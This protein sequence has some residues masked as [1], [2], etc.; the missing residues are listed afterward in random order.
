MGYIE[1]DKTELTNLK[2]SLSKEF[3]R[4]NRA[5]SYA[6]STIINCNTRKYHGLLI[7][8]MDQLDGEN[9]VLL[10]ALDETIIQHN[11]EF[12]LAVR[13]YPGVMHPGHKYLKEFHADP[14]P[15]LTY[16]VGGV[17]LQK[18]M[19]LSSNEDQVLI[20]YTLLDAHS[21]TTLKLHPFLAFRNIHKLCKAN[22]DVNTKFTKIENGIR[23]RMYNVYPYLY[24]QISKKN[25]YVPAPCWFYN[26]EYSEEES[27]GYEFTEDLYV[28]GYFEFPI[29]KGESIIF[30]ASLKEDQPKQLKQKFLEEIE[31]RIPRDNFENCL[32]NS[33]QQFIVHKKNKIEIVAGYPWFGP[34]MR[35]TFIALPGLTLSMGDFQTA[36]DVLLQIT[37]Q[38]KDGLFKNGDNEEIISVDT[39]LWYFW[40]IQQYVLYTG[41]DEESWKDFGSKMKSIL[42]KYKSGFD[43]VKMHDN[44]L[45]CAAE[46]GK[47]LTWMDAVVNGVPVTP[48]YGYNVEVNALWY[49]ALMFTLELAEK[50]NDQKFIKEWKEWPEKIKESFISTFWSEKKRFLSDY[51]TNGEQNWHVRP[52]QVFAISLPYSMLSKE[53][54]KSVLDIVEGELLTSRGL[55]TLSPNSSKY[56]GVYEG[57]PESRDNAY[58]QGTVWPWLLGGFCEAYLKIHK[59]SGLQKVKDI[60]YGFESDLANAGIGTISEIYDGIPPHEPKGAISQAWSVAELLRIKNIIDKYEEMK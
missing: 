27:R 14:M 50:F 42:S 6:G 25:E 4:S 16:R 39:A 37:K 43:S 55:R 3:I 20:R 36:R 46:Q 35:D 51:V 54:S 5:G 29:K 13:K 30:S 17:L 12:H 47:A 40:S 56:Q 22:L 48:R 32:T 28:P 57:N 38:S 21:P 24:M 53:I 59:K 19:V 1:F 15:T 7:C 9:H 41:K 58:H 18:E 8:P 52:N 44:G 33:A 10:S 2:Y 45:I 31:S 23:T 26:V 49:N 60:Y 34:R 11:K